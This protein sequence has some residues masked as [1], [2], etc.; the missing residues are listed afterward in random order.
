MDTKLKDSND[1][2]WLLWGSLYAAILFAVICLLNYSTPTSP[3]PVTELIPWQFILWG[4]LY[5]PIIVGPIIAGWKVTGFGFS[6]SPQLGLACLL[7]IGLCG[8]LTGGASRDSLGGAAIEAFARTGEEVFF[9]GFLFFIFIRLFDHQ[10][11]AWLWAVFGTSILFAL[12][13]T[14]TF[15]QSFPNQDGSSSAAGGYAIIERLLN[16]FG[17]AVILGLL[18]AWTKS[19]LPGAMIHGLLNSGILTMPFILVIYFLLIFWAYR[20]GEQILIK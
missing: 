19:I 4:F 3:G 17:A 7:V 5:L 12:A 6:L 9:R 15:Q 2:K 1:K 18:R 16:V 20:R 8:P 10:R 13:H 11:K 14:Q